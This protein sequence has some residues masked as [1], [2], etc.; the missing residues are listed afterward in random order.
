MHGHRLPDPTCPMSPTP[1]GCCVLG[2]M[3]PA[4]HAAAGR[5][6]GRAVPYRAVPCRAVRWAGVS[7]L[8]GF[9]DPPREAPVPQASPV[10]G[11]RVLAQPPQQQSA[12]TAAAEKHKLC[13][14]G[15]PPPCLPP[16]EA[17]V[18]LNVARNSTKQL[19]DLSGMP[20][21]AYAP[22]TANS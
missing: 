7:L 5:A 21:D 6:M 8:A 22:S 1:P 4:S 10:Q 12:A 14:L 9:P 17:F 11:S 18:T 3:A 19:L 13:S 20:W 15:L 2:R 16:G